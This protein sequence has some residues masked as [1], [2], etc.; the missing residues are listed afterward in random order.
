MRTFLLNF[1]AA[2]CFCFGTTAMANV[3]LTPV[4]ADLFLFAPECP[5]TAQNGCNDISDCPPNKSCDWTITNTT[6][7]GVRKFH[8]HCQ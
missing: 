5:G 7:P 4:M 8:C 2:M 6:T 1:V 3:I